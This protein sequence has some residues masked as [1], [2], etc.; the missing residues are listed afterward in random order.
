MNEPAAIYNTPWTSMSLTPNM[1][2]KIAHKVG[3]KLFKSLN[4]ILIIKDDKELCR[5]TTELGNS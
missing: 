1:H 2:S 3:F 5:D 4:Y